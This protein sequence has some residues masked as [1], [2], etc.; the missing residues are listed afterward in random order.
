MKTNG[1]PQ[2]YATCGEFIGPGTVPWAVC[3]A[4]VWS[5][6]RTRFFET[7]HTKLLPNGHQQEK[8]FSKTY[9]PRPR[10]VTVS[11][12]EGGVMAEEAPPR[13]RS[14]WNGIVLLFV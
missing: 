1:C 10:D 14:S 5:T 11:S 13:A 4:F 3:A 12:R 9:G 2:Q 8:G 6:S 7:L